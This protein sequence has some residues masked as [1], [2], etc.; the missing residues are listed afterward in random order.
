MYFLV[1]KNWIFRKL[2]ISIMRRMTLEVTF[3]DAYPMAT[4]YFTPAGKEPR[5][6]GSRS[7]DPFLPVTTPKNGEKGVRAHPA[8]TR[9]PEIINISYISKV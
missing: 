9:G 8:L 7:R 2:Y 1:K 6:P 5:A 3:R 4:T